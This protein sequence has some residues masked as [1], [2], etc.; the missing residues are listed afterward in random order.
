MKE[1]KTTRTVTYRRHGV[2]AIILEGKWLADRYEWKIGDQI[3]IEYLPNE[4]RLHKSNGVAKQ[5]NSFPM[6]ETN[7]EGNK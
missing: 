2:P 1:P 5:L 4:I 3:Q 6:G 7:P